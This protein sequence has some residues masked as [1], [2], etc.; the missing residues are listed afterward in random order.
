MNEQELF[1]RESANPILQSGNMPFPCKAV[2][3][4]AASLVDGETLLL[5]RAI[6][7]EDRSHLVVARSK[8]GIGG[9]RIQDPPLLSP[10]QG[11]GLV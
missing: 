9:W 6:D 3:N 8:D 2:C 7:N 1:K 5:L 4:P 10:Q 11:A